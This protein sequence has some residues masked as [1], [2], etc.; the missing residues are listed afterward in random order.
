MKE[1]ED[2][3]KAGLKIIDAHECKSNTCGGDACLDYCVDDALKA[4]A[5][6]AWDKGVRKEV[7][8][9]LKAIDRAYAK[10]RS[11]AI[12]IFDMFASNNFLWRTQ[13]KELIREEMRKKVLKAKEQK[14]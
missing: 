1:I 5:E 12:R 6:H 2:A 3:I 10:G 7:I 8:E 9:S 4:T 13:T 14:E 11:D